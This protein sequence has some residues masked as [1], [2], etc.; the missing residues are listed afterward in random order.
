MHPSFHLPEFGK[1]VFRRA[2]DE[3]GRNA[4]IFYFSTYLKKFLKWPVLHPAARTRMN[5]QARINTGRGE[6]L[7]T[8]FSQT[9]IDN[10]YAFIGINSAEA[11]T[12]KMLNEEILKMAG[13]TV[14]RSRRGQN[15]GETTLQVSAKI[16]I[17]ARG[18]P[19]IKFR[20]YPG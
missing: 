9:L 7:S 5:H 8:R 17:P 4:H 15:P 16:L 3:S 19:E 11:G 10:H 6:Y 14:R 18:Y 13:V 1:L 2:N 12:K 20:Q